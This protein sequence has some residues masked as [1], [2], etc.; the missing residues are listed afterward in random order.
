MQFNTRLQADKG[1]ALRSVLRQE[2]KRV[3]GLSVVSMD[4]KRVR[5]RVWLFGAWT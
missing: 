4:A 1:K 3:S 2:W 5:V